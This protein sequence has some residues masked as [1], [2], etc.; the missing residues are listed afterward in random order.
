VDAQILHLYALVRAPTATRGAVP[1][2]KRHHLPSP[3]LNFLQAG[4]PAPAMVGARTSS[5]RRS[6]STPLLPI[7]S[8]LALTS[9]GNPLRVYEIQASSPLVW[10]RGHHLP[11][12]QAVDT[13]C[14][15]LTEEL[16]LHTFP[17]RRIDA[18][19]RCLAI[20]S[21]DFHN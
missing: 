17:L 5:L 2:P 11:A 4:N 10:I 9:P 18:A 6:W 7:N 19:Q 8:P 20:I 14:A 3:T 16:D 12:G 21:E 13:R 15:A 1:Q